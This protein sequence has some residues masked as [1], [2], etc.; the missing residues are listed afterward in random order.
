MR[1]RHKPNALPELCASPLYVQSPTEYKGSW[2]SRFSN[3]SSDMFVE[4]GCGKGAFA[5]SLSSSHPEINLLA[6]DIKS[7]MLYSTMQKTVRAFEAIG[8]TPQ[9]I[10]L[11]ACDIERIFLILGDGDRAGGIFINFCNPW[12]KQKQKKKRL[13][14]TRQLIKYRDFL[15]DGGFV[16]LKTDDRELYE[17]SLNYFAE[18]NFEV[19]VSSTDIYSDGLAENL[20]QTEHEKQ[21]REYGMPIFYIKAVKKQ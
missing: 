8:K 18:A 5:A 13:T 12:F 4:L 3:P 7:E 9:N 14:H 11:A 16:E 17:D 2:N 20:I 6:I 15:A 1:I 21:F 19:T 10:L